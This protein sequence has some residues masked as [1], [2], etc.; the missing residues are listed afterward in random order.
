MI[1]Q[2]R[3]ILLSVFRK[4]IG[5]RF[6]RS[7]IFSSTS[8]T[9][10]NQKSH[11]CLLRSLCSS[12]IQVDVLTLKRPLALLHPLIIQYCEGGLGLVGV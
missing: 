9:S 7:V 6:Y 11:S 5:I 2:E 10:I 12:G 1:T 4:W 3:H 8:K